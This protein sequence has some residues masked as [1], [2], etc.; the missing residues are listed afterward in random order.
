ML[1]EEPEDWVEE[2]TWEGTDC[3]SGIPGPSSDDNYFHVDSMEE[4][5]NALGGK[6]PE[7]VVPTKTVNQLIKKVENEWQQEAISESISSN[8]LLQE[9]AQ[10]FDELYEEC[11]SSETIT[12]HYEKTLGSNASV[13]RETDTPEQIIAEHKALSWTACYNDSCYIHM[14]N[15]DA[16]GYY[17]KKLRKP[18]S[19][20][21]REARET[22]KPGQPT[23]KWQDAVVEPL[24][25]EVFKGERKTGKGQT[26][27]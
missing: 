25:W 9:L 12:D 14:L 19:Q 13:E 15:K 11:L 2:D 27:W 10:E 23:L 24:N 6:N 7:K 17:P 8:T 4:F 3:N 20:V 26:L 18:R 1:R 5:Q 22:S 16:T 21:T